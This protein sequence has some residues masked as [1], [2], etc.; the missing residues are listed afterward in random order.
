MDVS[1]AEYHHHVTYDELAQVIV[2]ISNRQPR[3]DA[4]RSNEAATISRNIETL[5]GNACLPG[6]AETVAVAIRNHKTAALIFDRI[7]GPKT[8]HVG[9][10]DELLVWGATPFE[11]IFMSLG[12]AGADDVAGSLTRELFTEHGAA[13]LQRGIASALVSAHAIQAIPTYASAA[14]L[15]SEYAAGRRDVIVAALTNLEV[16]DERLLTW[17]QVLE[18]RAD[19][20]SRRDYRRMLNWLDR[21]MIGKTAQQVTDEIAD[22][23]ESYHSALRKHAIGTTAGVVESLIDPKFLAAVASVTGAIALTTELL[24]GVASASALVAARIACSLAKRAVDRPELR[25][26]ANAVVAY[27]HEVSKLVK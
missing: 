1:P 27:V 14:A 10:P 13:P 22:R 6:P 12:A 9:I 4:F 24:A 15:E 5:F 25:T 17:E 16:V 26:G 8:L 2:G 21:D 3:E 18:F 20:I 11:I 23:L 7:W 19:P